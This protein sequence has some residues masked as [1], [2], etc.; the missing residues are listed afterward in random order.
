MFDSLKFAL[1]KRNI[2]NH[3]RN[4]L[5]FATN[6]NLYTENIHLDENYIMKY[7][8]KL[9]GTKWMNM[10]LANQS[11]SPAFL[12][13]IIK[14]L[15]DDEI[16]Q[17]LCTQNL[18]TRFIADNIRFFNT[19]KIWSALCSYQNLSEEFI[20]SYIYNIKFKELTR[21]H[22]LSNDFIREHRD[23]LDWGEVSIYQNLSE[24]F[25]EEMIDYVVPKFVSLYQKVS[26]DFIKDHGL[27]ILVEERQELDYLELRKR[28]E[29]MHC[30]VDIYKVA[31]YVQ[32]N[33]A[34]RVLK[35]N[36][37]NKIHYKDAVV[38]APH[39]NY[40]LPYE[41]EDL[42]ISASFGYTPS[43]I[44]KKPP[45]NFMVANLGLTNLAKVE[46]DYRDITSISTEKRTINC[47]KYRVINVFK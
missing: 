2:I 22:K 8:D 23:E 18:D 6:I 32:L 19:N 35:G 44:M 5:K 24:K 16:F 13:D 33:N 43:W 9:K 41:L 47:S 34:N 26:K 38:T 21:T 39:C 45:I 36:I 46:I 11:F 37:S 29:D 12:Y 15:N 28:L 17:L 25:I 7:I 40:K 3:R 20:D 4:F 42:S 10:I 30:E 14:L 1:V 31:A 27:N